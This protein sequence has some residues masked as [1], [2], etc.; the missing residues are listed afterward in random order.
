MIGDAKVTITVEELDNLRNADEKW[1][2][3][4][5]ESYESKM[6]SLDDRQKKLDKYKKILNDGERILHE[7]A[8]DYLILCRHDGWPCDIMFEWMTRKDAFKQ[9]END[10]YYGVKG[11]I[12]SYLYETNIFEIMKRKWD[13]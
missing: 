6:K 7:K 2:K 10:F 12:I 11:K 5:K 8:G 4:Y 1:K 3:F 9:F 13:W